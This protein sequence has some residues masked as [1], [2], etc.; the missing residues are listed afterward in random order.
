MEP[1]KVISD[2]YAAV[3]IVTLDG[4]VVVGRIMNLAGDVLQIN[5]NMLDP[6]AITPVDRKTIDE[7]EISKTSMMPTGLL[8]SCNEEELLDL[9][10][11][12]L[13]RGDRAARSSGSD[14]GGEH[15]GAARRN[16][17]PR[18]L[19]PPPCRHSAANSNPTCDGSR[20]QGVSPLAAGGTSLRH[21]G[22]QRASPLWDRRRELTARFAI[23]AGW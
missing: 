14:A 12:L 9:M 19:E 3:Q 16:G 1:S 6:S 2:Q 21:R 11:Y 22:T 20:G 8:N 10:A 5:T 23:P 4:K 18:C 7:M 13:S 15:D 17:T